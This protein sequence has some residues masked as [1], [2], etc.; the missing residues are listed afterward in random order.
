[1]LS[2]ELVAGEPPVSQ[3][4]PHAA[5]GVRH[6]LPQTAC[7]RK[8]LHGR[9]CAPA[10]EKRRATNDANRGCLQLGD[11]S[12]LTPHPSPLPVEGRGSNAGRA[13]SSR[14]CQAR[15]GG[16]PMDGAA[17]AQRMQALVA[18]TL[19]ACTRPWR[20]HVLD[21]FAVVA[22]GLGPRV[23]RGFLGGANGRRWTV[24]VSVARGT[25]PLF[26]WLHHRIPS[27]AGSASA[28]SKTG[29]RD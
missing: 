12:A 14:C 26:H 13:R 22:N 17:V 23:S 4:P 7:A 2:A 5:L 9:Q 25:Q 28:V 10:H 6:R 11:C 8:I 1:M 15:V 18:F 16:G 3:Q 27:R 24:P 20:R 29:K 21:R 19:P